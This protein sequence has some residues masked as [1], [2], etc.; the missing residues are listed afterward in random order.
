VKTK[1]RVRNTNARKKYPQKTVVEKYER[2]P[3]GK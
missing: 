1:R 2:V 3:F